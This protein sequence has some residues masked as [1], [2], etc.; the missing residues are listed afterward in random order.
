M[1]TT[2]YI[3]IFR[4]PPGEEERVEVDLHTGRFIEAV[5]PAVYHKSLYWGS[6]AS[7]IH[8]EVVYIRYYPIHLLTI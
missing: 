6:N 7:S 5:R 2:S 3:L 8:Q 1:T 4:S